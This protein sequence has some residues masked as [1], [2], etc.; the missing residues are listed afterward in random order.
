MPPS[1]LTPV[2]RR[3]SQAVLPTDSEDRTRDFK[4]SKLSRCNS[5]FYL[6]KKWIKVSKL[7]TAST[8][9]CLCFDF[10]DKTSLCAKLDTLQ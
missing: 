8:E 2:S 4:L 1:V 7:F 10:K 6:R 9:L 3:L 5:H